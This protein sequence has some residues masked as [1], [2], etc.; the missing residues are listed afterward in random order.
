MF[1]QSGIHI[2]VLSQF[3]AVVNEL[4]YLSLLC[5]IDW[6]GLSNILKLKHLAYLCVMLLCCLQAC[7]CGN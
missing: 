1:I 3:V 6:V 7:I 5:I 2:S 4:S